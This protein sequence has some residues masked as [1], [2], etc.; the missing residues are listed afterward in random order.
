MPRLLAAC[1][2]L[3][4]PIC[5][6]AADDARPEETRPVCSSHNQGQLWPEAANHDS[7]L[8][9][10]LVR[11]GELY[12][13]VRG[14]WHYHWESPSVRLDQLGRGAKQNAAKPS[15]CEEQAVVSTPPADP[16][17]ENGSR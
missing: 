10:R 16:G 7:R 2:G 6:L 3:M 5:C 8:L 1:L 4:L 17:V 9:A 15:I 12:V 14:T 11:C 13:C